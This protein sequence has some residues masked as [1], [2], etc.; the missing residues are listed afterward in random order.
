MKNLIEEIIEKA[1][2]KFNSIWEI[3][4]VN[5]IE[6]LKLAGR[7]DKLPLT[8]K[9]KKEYFDFL[10]RDLIKSV[11]NYI[12][13]TDEYTNLNVEC[14][15]EFVIG[16]EII[17]DNK[18]YYFGTELIQAGGYNIQCLHYR[19]IAHTDLPRLNINY[20]YESLKNNKD[21]NLM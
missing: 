11:G 9:D 7:E 19:Y 15:K 14:R 1:E 4:S 12:Q 8:E 21:G 13:P 17:R 10:T 3:Y 18:K 5:L 2:P 6:R 16:C 20:Y